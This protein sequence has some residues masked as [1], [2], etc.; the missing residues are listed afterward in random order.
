MTLATPPALSAELTGPKYAYR[1]HRMTSSGRLW[2][3]QANVDSPASGS[4]PI[5]TAGWHAL[6]EV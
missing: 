6:L 2:G 1:V 4:G 3:R 5:I